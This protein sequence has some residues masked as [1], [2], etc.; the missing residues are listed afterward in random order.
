MFLRPDEE[1]FATAGLISATT[2]T[3]TAPELRDR[4]R[5]LKDAGYNEIVVQVTP[6]R[7]TMLDDWARVFETV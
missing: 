3:A 2:M 7:E 4:I 6:G 1:R 5:R